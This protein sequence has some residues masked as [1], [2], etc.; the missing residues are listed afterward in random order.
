MSR[1]FVALCL[2]VLAT[3]CS[4]SSGQ[5]AKATDDSNAEFAE[6]NNPLVQARLEARVEN[7]KYQRGVTLVTNLERIAAYGEIAI[8]VCLEGIKSDDAMTR[9][10]CAWVL[11][12]V[13][14][15]KTIPELETLLEDEVAFVRYEAASQLGSLGARTGYGTLVE[16]LKNDK[17]EYRYKCHEALR[18]LTKQDFGYSHNASPELRADAVEKWAAWLEELQAEDL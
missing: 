17:L 6:P 2:A 1:R 5:S 10:G 18:Q 12:R 8:A 9:M 15:P 4:S 14:N 7:I 11:G 13:G 16:G 3:S